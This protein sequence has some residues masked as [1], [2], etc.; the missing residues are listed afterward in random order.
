MSA[1]HAANYKALHNKLSYK[2]RA[3][4]D[5]EEQAKYQS[6]LEKLSEDREGMLQQWAKDH[7][8]SWI[9][10][11]TQ[12][13]ELK[14]VTGT[15]SEEVELNR[16]QVL[17]EEGLDSFPE[18]HE[19]VSSFLDSLKSR[20][21]PIKA[22]ADKGEKLYTYSKV[23]RTSQDL[24]VSGL[25]SSSNLV[26]AEDP[27]QPKP[28]TLKITWPKACKQILGQCQKIIKQME[29]HASH[30]RGIKSMCVVKGALLLKVE[31]EKAEDGMKAVMDSWSLKMLNEPHTEQ[32]HAH[33]KDLQT[34]MVGH[35]SECKLLIGKLTDSI[36][37]FVPPDQMHVEDAD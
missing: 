29:G 5:P 10:S 34:E 23:K 17:K 19:L 9:S 1:D 8:L 21:H 12:K 25:A 20:E 36:K 35:A 28:S 11:V 14:S 33:L 2:A 37:S 4:S 32:G 27:A 3:T 24:E 30:L 7:S 22:W 15:E 6:A 26:P 13:E 18:N 31:A 16:F